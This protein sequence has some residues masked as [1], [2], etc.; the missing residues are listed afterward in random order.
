MGGSTNTVLHTLAL[1]R[2]RRASN[3]DWR[4]STRSP[5]GCRTSARCRRHRATTSRTWIGPAASRRSCGSSS[6]RPG[7]LHTDTKTVTGKTLLENVQGAES[8]D[9]ACIRPLENPVQRTR[10]A[11]DPVRQPG[12]RRRGDQDRRRRCRR[13][14]S[15]A[16][17]RWCSTRTTRPTR[18]SSSGKVKAG[19]VVVIRY[20]GPKGGPGMQEM[21]APTSNIM[22]MGLGSSV[23]LLTDGRFSGGTAA[24]ASA[25]SRPRPR[26]AG[27]S[28]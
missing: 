17:R 19:D 9:T 27:R 12:A 18:A 25:T 3:I 21:L 4:G 23:A 13:C 24:R 14:C 15:I 16:A 26:P 11:G 10:R 7:I 28:A 5:S 2:M 8:L 6:K 1:A 22:G 20:E